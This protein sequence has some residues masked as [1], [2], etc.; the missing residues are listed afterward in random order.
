MK[1]IFT[2]SA[3]LAL[4]ASGASAQTENVDTVV[5]D[6]PDRVVVTSNDQT[7]TVAVEGRD[8]DPAYRFN[9]SQTLMG[10]G[11]RIEKEERSDFDFT[12]PFTRSNTSSDYS[13]A[14]GSHGTVEMTAGAFR[15][16]WA[17]ALGAPSEMNT[18]FG[19]SWEFALR[20]FEFKV[21]Y[22]HS[23]WSFSSGLW[24]NWRNYRMTGPM[25]FVKNAETTNIELLPY[26]DNAD[27]DFSRI[28]IYSLEVPLTASLS[29]GKK[30]HL[31]FGPVFSFNS[32]TSIKTR[33]SIDG[34]DVKDYT[35]GIHAQRF[36]IDLMAQAR[37]SSFGVYVK[38]SPCNVLNPDYAPKFHGISTGLGLF[39]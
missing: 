17:N 25:R 29:L 21:R 11:M 5:I 35:R 33:Y 32:R 38:Y 10:D 36:T 1:K 4:T 28:K 2:I 3:L 19:Q 27:R 18:P 7:L 6:K 13:S 8:G 20:C 26:P 31:D 9:K 39:Y 23:R 24:L 15:F 30:F 12:L 16:G 34:H 22:N 14:K 37:V